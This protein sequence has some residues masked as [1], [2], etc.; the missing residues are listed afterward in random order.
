MPDTRTICYYAM[1]VIGEVESRWDWTA[2]NYNDPITI[3]MMQWYGTRAA[4]LLNRIQSEMPSAYE[5]LAGSLRASLA[6]HGP[7]DGYWTSFYLN[8]EE[9]QS[10]VRVFQSQEN[11]VIQENQAIADFEGYI[12]T[13]ESWGMSQAYPKPLIFTMAMY[14]QNPSRAG[15]VIASCGGTADLELVYTTCL[16]EPILG[17]YRTR[18]DTVYQRLKEW[19]GESMPP[20]FGQVGS[21]V[22]GGNTGISRAANKLTYAIQRGDQLIVFGRDEYAN[23]VTFFPAGIQRWKCAVNAEGA[24]IIG[25]NS[26]GGSGPVSDVVALYVSWVGMFAY[27][28]GPGRLT[29]LESGY[30][31]CSSTIWAAYQQA[32]GIDVGTYTGAMEELGTLIASSPGTL[33]IDQMQP[34]DLLLTRG[35]SSVYPYA[36]VEM[37]IGNNQLCGHGGPDNGP[38]IKQDAQY[39]ASLMANWTVR[40]YA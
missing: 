32:A 19:D 26:G 23:G 1:Y 37:Y 27:S 21:G 8:Q 13:L 14:H 12:S 25:G 17:Q 5:Q 20:D 7:D 16:N 2:I 40:R 29:P 34:G 9:G 11:H 10:I 31:D 22:I 6:A 33:P 36:H 4:G 24:A 38:T 3:G 28:Q 35:G 30:G 39:T 15:N 18:Y